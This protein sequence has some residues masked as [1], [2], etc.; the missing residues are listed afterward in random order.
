MSETIRLRTATAADA[1]AMLAIRHDAIMALAEEYGR[2]EAERWI[3]SA[4]PDRADRAILT[5][6]VWVAEVDGVAVGWVEVNGA[7][8]EGLYVSPTAAR[9]GVGSVLLAHA[10]RHIR[11]TGGSVAYLDASPN[12]EA[13]YARRG[14]RRAGEIKANNSRPMSKPLAPGAS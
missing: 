12:A 11:E 5:H 9:T 2:E 4:R 6:L 3:T 13:F 8:V 7:T 14:Y 10:E 1:S